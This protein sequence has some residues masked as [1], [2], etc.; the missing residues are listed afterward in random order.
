MP[1]PKQRA[2]IVTDRNVAAAAAWGRE[3]RASRQK[4]LLVVRRGLM[5]A[6]LVACIGA[7]LVVPPRPFLVWNVSASAPTGLYAV[8]G[9]SDLSVGDMVIARMPEP[10]RQFAARRHYLPANVPLVKSVAA[11]AG[12]RVCAFGSK[13]WI[14]GRV[15][16]TRRAVDGAGRGLP[17]WSNCLTLKSGDLLLLMDRPDSF[18][19]RYFGITG[20]SDVVGRAVPLWTR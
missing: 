17:S 14:S 2:P 16:G 20:E 13:L 9:R 5:V 19:G 12:D 15:A 10:W 4:R 7:T 1:A 3:L 11:V 8:T 6:G 18:D